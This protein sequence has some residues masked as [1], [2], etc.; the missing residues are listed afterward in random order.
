MH[1]AES[2]TDQGGMQSLGTILQISL[3]EEEIRGRLKETEGTITSLEEQLKQIKEQLS[4][5]LSLK[6]EVVKIQL[7]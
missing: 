5:K 2:R 7:I 4:V 3:R 6:H 1:F